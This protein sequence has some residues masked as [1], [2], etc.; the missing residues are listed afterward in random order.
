[1]IYTLSIH[2]GRRYAPSLTFAKCYCCFRSFYACKL[3]LMLVISNKIAKLGLYRFCLT[4]SL[5]AA[6]TLKMFSDFFPLPLW[7]YCTNC[8]LLIFRI[9]PLAI[10]ICLFRYNCSHFNSY[11]PVTFIMLLISCFFVL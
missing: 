7:H 4:I 2:R 6:S 11:T 9:T 5:I 8:T 3:L 1:M 10:C